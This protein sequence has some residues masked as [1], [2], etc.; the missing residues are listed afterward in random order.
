MT[1]PHT[2]KTGQYD[3]FGLPPN[4]TQVF[5]TTFH[6][7]LHLPAPDQYIRGKTGNP[8]NTTKPIFDSKHFPVKFLIF[9]LIFNHPSQSHQGISCGVWPASWRTVCWVDPCPHGGGW[10]IR[11]GSGQLQGW[12]QLSGTQL[13]PHNRKKSSNPA[14]LSF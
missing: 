7:Y 4:K 11:R 10:R 1:L 9:L 8:Q 2:R 6:T 13:V 3:S 5:S 14:G 12:T